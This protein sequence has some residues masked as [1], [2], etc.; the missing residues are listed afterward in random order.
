MITSAVLFCVE[1][2]AEVARF[3][4]GDAAPRFC[5]EMADIRIANAKGPYASGEG[6]IDKGLWPHI[7]GGDPT[8][9]GGCDF[10][11]MRGDRPG[12]SIDPGT[13]SHARGDIS[14]CLQAFKH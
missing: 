2:P 6:E 12:D 7:S 9:I 13:D 11:W 14:F 4:S 10:R 5:G 3:A 1:P 8:N